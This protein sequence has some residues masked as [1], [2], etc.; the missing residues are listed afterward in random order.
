[1]YDRCYN[2]SKILKMYN[3]TYLFIL[4]F[5]AKSGE[6]IPKLFFGRNTSIHYSSTYITIIRGRTLFYIRTM[7]KQRLYI[8]SIFN[9]DG[10][11]DM[12]MLTAQYL[13]YFKNNGIRWTLTKTSKIWFI[14]K[15]FKKH[16]ILIIFQQSCIGGY[17]VIW[18]YFFINNK[19][20]LFNNE[21]YFF[22]KVYFLE[23]MICYNKFY[24]FIHH[25]HITLPTNDVWFFY[26]IKIMSVCS[27]T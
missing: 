3:A 2:L 5:S 14:E 12:Y 26:C 4:P 13:S 20:T 16:Y 18:W 21:Q 19:F 15:Y 9:M 23:I 25:V 24:I 10:L 17:S 27:L 11:I 1:M 7:N 6:I 22:S 8:H